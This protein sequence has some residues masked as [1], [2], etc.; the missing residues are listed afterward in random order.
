LLNQGEEWSCEEWKQWVV[1][2]YLPYRSWQVHNNQFDKEVE[3]TVA[4]FSEWYIDKYVSIHKD[5]D[6]SLTHCL[7]SLASV[8]S[9]NEFSIILL[10]DCLPVTYMPL[11]ESELSNVGFSRHELGYRFALLPTST[12]YN[13]PAL[14]SGEW[15]N[16]ERNYEKILNKR[17]TAEWIGK[18]GIYLS[19]LKA[20]S[21]MT[22]P[23]EPTIAV[24]NLVD[25]D[26]LLHSDVESQNTT[27]EE[28]LHRLFLR[29]AESL[30]RVADG[31]PGPKDRVSVYVVTDHGACRLLEEERCSFDSTVVN[32]LFTDEK[33][34]FAPIEKN[35]VADIPEN[36]FDL[37]Y[38]FKRPF[39]SD[40]KT[41]FLP[42][43]HN[44]VRQTSRVKGFLHGGV[45]PEEVIVPTAIYKLIKTAWKT[46][47]ARF[48]N[49]DLVRE[50]GRAK[51]YIQRVVTLQVDIQNPNTVDIRILR[52]SVTSP[53]TDLKSCEVAVVIPAGGA[54]ILQMSCYFK[55]SA[56]EEKS[57][58]IEIAYE[59]SGEQHTLPFSLECEFKSAMAGGFNLKNL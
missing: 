20:M 51:F 12:E 15:D 24:L 41:Y 1:E 57:L 46:P 14:F 16:D 38:K 33:H 54:N 49:L 17:I 55:K 52:A 43:G 59:V 39:V 35:Q 2:K 30:H 37:G 56:L 9:E 21:E 44:T 26:K 6:L 48:P 27:Y 34:R 25:G 23:H 47:V 29:L 5:P 32:K 7:R 31:W 58:A 53:E 13:K 3:Q 40:D 8:D 11:L 19:N 50:T 42:R 18:K 45:T 28:E 22:V 4:R 10:L 36:L